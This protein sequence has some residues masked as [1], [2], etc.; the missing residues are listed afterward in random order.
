MRALKILAVLTALIAFGATA[1]LAKSHMNYS[2][3][4]TMKSDKGMGWV[5]LSK[6]KGDM[7]QFS[8]MVNNKD[9]ATCNID[10]MIDLPEGVGIYKGTYQNCNFSMYFEKNKVMIDSA[11]TCAQCG[12]KAFIDGAYTTGK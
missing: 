10:G 11:K 7:Y 8:I 6:V 2:G 1:A 12:G 9:G 4:Y 3:T 5:K